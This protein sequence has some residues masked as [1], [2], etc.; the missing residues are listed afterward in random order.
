MAEEH[1][2]ATASFLAKAMAVMCV[3]NT[4]LEDIHDGIHPV[5]HTGDFSDVVVIDAN[6]R[7]IPWTR[8]AHIQQEEM[9]ELMRQIVNRLY[10]VNLKA[11]DMDFLGMLDRAAMEAGKWDEPELDEI[12]IKGLER[13][14]RRNEQSGGASSE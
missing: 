14:R 1:E 6:G 13:R 2:V 5:T 3:R 10:T 12:T 7:R 8:V 9:R 11:G 4:I